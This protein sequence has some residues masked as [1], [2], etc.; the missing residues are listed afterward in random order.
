MSKDL[1]SVAFAEEHL[2]G[3]VTLDDA[4]RLTG[5]DDLYEKHVLEPLGL[6]LEIENKREKAAAELF[7]G[8]TYHAGELFAGAMKQDPNI[9]ELAFSYP[10]GKHAT[11]SGV[12]N[13]EGS[14]V[15]LAM[16]SKWETAEMKRVVAHVNT[17]FDEISN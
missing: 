4:N 11:A 8:V 16:T 10:M 13:R 3:V 5:L 2:K 1:K 6:T 17:L 14:H 12:F 7:A 9:S 15:V